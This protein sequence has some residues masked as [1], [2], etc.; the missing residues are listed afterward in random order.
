MDLLNKYDERTTKAI[1]EFIEDFQAIFP[2]LLSKEELIMRI[3]TNLK[4]INFEAD[5]DDKTLG[6]YVNNNILI[7]KKVFEK[8]QTLFHE[9]IHVITD[10]AFLQNK[11]YKNFIEG[12]TT[13]AEEIYMQYKEIKK[14]KYRRN[15]N[16]YIPTFVRELNFITDG[17]ALEQFLV[18]PESVSDSFLS[19]LL[20]FDL[21]PSVISKNKKNLEFNS[22]LRTNEAIVLNAIMG[23]SDQVI[24]PMIIELEKKIL[25]Q[26]FLRIKTNKVNHILILI[27]MHP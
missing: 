3:N 2:G 23:N 14:P 26:Y 5:L 21:P 27:L 6:R 11:D 9:F 20:K 12:M 15:I 17:E 13:L 10:G 25:Q 19:V 24:V 1:W 4:S 22:F 8:G 16:G 18:S 7:N